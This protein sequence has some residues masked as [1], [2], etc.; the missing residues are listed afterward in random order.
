ML[1][2]RNKPKYYC[3]ADYEYWKERNKNKV[4]VPKTVLIKRPVY[5]SSLRISKLPWL[6]Q[7][8]KRET[9][10]DWHHWEENVVPQ[11]YSGASFKRGEWG[12]QAIDWCSSYGLT[13]WYI[14]HSCKTVTTVDTNDLLRKITRHNLRKLGTEFYEQKFID[15]D[16]DKYTVVDAVKQID[17]SIYDTIRIGSL[18]YSTIYDTIKDQL[19]ANVK[20]AIYKP[21]AD[22]VQKMHDENYELVLNPKGVD[23]FSRG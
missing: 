4:I 23:Y 12:D 19:K 6:W 21:R 11:Q 10:F 22:F 15:V 17:W 7:V 8:D 5:Q 2:S 9:T 16:C 14:G 3:Q 13:S 20:I 18:S 1:K